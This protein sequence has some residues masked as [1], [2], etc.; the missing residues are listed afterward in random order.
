MSV[1]RHPKSWLV[2]LVA[3][4]ATGFAWL[5]LVNPDMAGLIELCGEN[6]VFAYVAPWDGGRLLGLGAMWCT[7]GVAMMVPCIALALVCSAWRWR[8]SYGFFTAALCHALGYFG[9]ALPLVIAAAGLEWGLESVGLVRGG[10]PPND[11][12]ISALF[13]SVGLGSLVW[14]RRYCSSPRPWLGPVQ[15]G[16]WHAY[17]HLPILVAMIAMQLAAGSMNFGAMFLLALAMLAL[18]FSPRAIRRAA[19]AVR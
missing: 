15:S 3:A 16:L 14:R 13:V 6:G 19:L 8:E 5:S 1:Y 11:P 10:S 4:L 12:A 17:R 2:L 7:M 18:E 9:V